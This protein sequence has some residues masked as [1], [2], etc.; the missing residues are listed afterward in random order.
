MAI[1]LQMSLLPQT[2]NQLMNQRR[3]AFDRWE[4]VRTKQYQ[5]LRRVAGRELLQ[6][7]LS[8]ATLCQL[9]ERGLFQPYW[10]NAGQWRDE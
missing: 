4:F 10:R 3:A 7:S 5:L 9:T 2:R 6:I 8:K 1:S